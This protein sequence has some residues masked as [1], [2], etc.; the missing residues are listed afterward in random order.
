MNNKLFEAKQYKDM[1]EVLNGVVSKYPSNIAFTIKTKKGANPEYRDVTF[2]EFKSE[3]DSFATGLI[4]LGLK[5]KRVAVIGKNSYEWAVT[6]FAVLSGVGII[7]PLDKGL[8][9][10]EIEDLMIRS[11]ADAIVFENAYLETMMKIKSN[12]STKI[13][14][15]ICMTNIENDE[16]ICFNNVVELGKEQLKSGNKA[17]Y[18][19]KINPESASVILF[20]SGTTSISKAVLL[21]QKNLMSDLYGIE[22]AIKVFPNDVNMAFLPFHHCLGAIGLITLLNG[23]A[24]VVF[25]DGLRYISQ[26]LKEYKV[27]V[28][29]CVPLILESMH[30][31]IIA[32]INKKGLNGKVN[33]AKKLSKILM[34]FGIDVRRKLFKTILDNLGG[35]VR[36]VVSGAAAIDRQ[37]VED[38]NAFGILTIQGYGLTETSPVLCVENEKS[39]RYGSIGFPL[40]NVEVKI[41]NPNEE[42][43]GEVIAKGPMVMLGYYNNQEATNEV[44]KDGW[45][46]T[47]DLGYIDSDGYVF[48][49]GRV[50]NVIV[51]KNGKN[52]YPEE[53][54]ILIS[55]LPYALENMVFG[56]PE[57]DDDLMLAVK[58]VYNEEMFANMEISEIE[59]RIWADIKEI[60]NSLT[61]YKHIKKLIIT[62]E[63]M[64]KTTTNKVK[65]N[66]EISKTLETLGIN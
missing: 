41:D 65:R 47:G 48:L 43:I 49:T 17:I 32:E 5:N 39:I 11:E 45:F 10:Q 62:T 29:F 25:C 38:F 50:K 52:V 28:F 37:V 56:I 12:K 13:K 9:E 20:T 26:N 4:K 19:A 60:N 22:S 30:K 63:P 53:L 2:R 64:I 61:T 8:P 42:G 21:S 3:V 34:K 57:S 14:N 66:I 54:E 1:R 55:G 33:F 27:T 36:L 31:K 16:V 15:F 51:L 7:V 58:L 35:G 6:Y 40:C 24:K 44:L 46:H 23:G 59:K 18:K